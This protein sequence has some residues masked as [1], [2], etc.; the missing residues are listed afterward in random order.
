MAS[1]EATSNF[2]PLRDGKLV[3]EL[4]RDPKKP[5]TERF[6]VI[7]ALRFFYNWKPDKY[8]KQ[9]LAALQ[10]VLQQGDIADLAIEDLR[11][12]KLWDLTDQVLSKYGKKSH[13]VPVVQRSIIRY[14]LSCP[15]PEAKHFVAEVR[16]RNPDLVRDLE[17]QLQ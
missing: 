13:D 2:V 12:W 4:L 14:A 7:R 6:A 17:M 9:V 5:F 15:L 16:R 11:R 10:L 8:K 3:N 1:S